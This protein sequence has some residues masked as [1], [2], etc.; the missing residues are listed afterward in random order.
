VPT[1]PTLVHDGRIITESTV[2]CG[3]V[4]DQW[5]D[6]PLKPRD[7]FGRAQMSVW[8]KQLDES[9]HPAYRVW[10]QLEVFR[11]L[12][13]AAAQIEVDAIPIEFLCG[14]CGPN[15]RGANWHI[16]MIKR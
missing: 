14:Q 15:L 5:P 2:I 7:S 6:Q 3:Y 1:V 10:I 13:V 11:L 16:V 8:T 12:R 9:L 4:D